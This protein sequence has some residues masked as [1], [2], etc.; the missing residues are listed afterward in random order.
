MKYVSHEDMLLI[1]RQLYNKGRDIDVAI[2]NGLVDE[3][4]QDFVLDCLML[5]MNR[6]GGFGS[7]LFIDNYNPNSSVYQTYEAFRILDCLG[8]DKHCSN[9]LFFE[10]VNKACNYLFNKCSL[11]DGAWN[12][13]VITNDDFAHSE[14]MSYQKNFKLKW[15][16]FPTAS[17]LG[18]IFSF[19]D[20]QKAYYKKALKQ[21]GY[22]FDYFEK[23]D[24]YSNYDLQAMNEL[25]GSLKKNNLFLEQQKIL[26]QKLCSYAMTN[27]SI[28]IPLFLSNCSLN[29]ELED[30]LNEQ[31]DALIADRKSHGLWEHQE[32]WQSNRY[33]EADSAALKWIGAETVRVIAILK[34]YGRIEK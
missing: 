31:L 11:E 2:F 20:E 18:Y 34:K 13:T 30:R 12:P 23:L 25:L 24:S 19:V 10:L 22:A 16:Y 15:D 8:F 9:P 5:Y 27:E 21:I 32:N 17:L 3:N 7:G 33:P 14:E 26:E 28:S 1:E 29:K 6:D 4:N